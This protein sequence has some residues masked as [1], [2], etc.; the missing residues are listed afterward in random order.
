MPS[1]RL[2]L[3]FLF[4]DFMTLFY[5]YL[6]WMSHQ[7][8]PDILLLFFAQI[9]SVSGQKQSC[10]APSEYLK[11]GSVSETHLHPPI[12]DSLPY[13]ASINPV[14][15]QKEAA[16]H[17]VICSFFPDFFYDQI[18]PIVYACLMPSRFC[19]ATAFTAF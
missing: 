13:R 11:T 18:P 5:L 7:N 6:Q 9:S 8:L 15:T 12:T 14:I 16:Y 1:F 2:F 17:I 19:F 3:S 4:S 10:S